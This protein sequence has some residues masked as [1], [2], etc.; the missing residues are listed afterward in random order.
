MPGE[1]GINILA[2]VISI[3]ILVAIL[4]IAVIILFIIKAGKN[5]NSGTGPQGSQGRQGVSGS[6]GV[7]GVQ[8]DIGLRGTQGPVGNGAGNATAVIN[9]LTFTSSTDTRFNSGALPN[10]IVVPVVVERI[11]KIVTLS[12]QVT[13]FVG[14]ISTIQ[15]VFIITLPSNAPLGGSLD[16]PQGPQGPIMSFSGNGTA[17]REPGTAQNVDLTSVAPAVPP[18]QFTAITLS[19]VLQNGAGAL[20]N[21][22]GQSPSWFCKFTV[23]YRTP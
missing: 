10:I 23:V 11:D 6:I 17:L 1:D 2:F 22:A 13:C 14:A 4:V 18:S 15:L 9:N 19:Y 5:T 3:S 7:S 20:W 16:G 12:G 8:G 21:G